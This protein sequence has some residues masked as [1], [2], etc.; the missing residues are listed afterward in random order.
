MNIYPDKFTAG[1][2]TPFF[3]ILTHKI[4]KKHYAGSKTAK[5]C[6]PED[7]WTKYFTS[8]KTIKQ[9]I[10]EE[11]AD[12]FNNSIKCVLHEEKF[13]TRINAATQTTWFNKTNGGITTVNKIPWIKGR[14]HSKE[15]NKRNSESHKG[16]IPWNKGKT[17]IFSSASLSAISIS[18][19][20]RVRTKES[21]EK[22]AIS[23]R[24]QKRSEEFKK[25][26]AEYSRNI[27][28]ETREKR[29]KSILLKIEKGWKPSIHGKRW[30]YH[31]I[32]KIPLKINKDEV[33][34]YILK[35]YIPGRKIKNL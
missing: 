8:S 35:G 26:V 9:I 28:N 21:I 15:S 23:N 14:K 33:D 16:K 31:P 6:R 3:Y 7:L 13:L 29:R 30:V 25:L 4:S 17:N 18:A 5:G 34:S 22:T 2:R 27:S 12:I 32:E 1:D 20:N 19:K 24:G 10:K 11:G